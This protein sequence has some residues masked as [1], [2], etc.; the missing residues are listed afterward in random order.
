MTQLYVDLTAFKDL[1]EA[2]EKVI[3]HLDYRLHDASPIKQTLKAA[4]AV[5]KER[6]T[7]AEAREEHWLVTKVIR[8]MEAELDA[9]RTP[10]LF[11]VG[12]ALGCSERTLTRQL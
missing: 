2:T 9:V 4:L 6:I 11:L 5:S 3:P 10:T 8:L 1:V 12:K 7:E